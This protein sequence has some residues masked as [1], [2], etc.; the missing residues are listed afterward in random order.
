MRVYN[1]LLR[2]TYEGVCRAS[3]AQSQGNFFI[4]VKIMQNQEHLLGTPSDDAGCVFVMIDF[5]TM[6]VDYASK[7]SKCLLGIDARRIEE[8]LEV[9]DGMVIGNASP[10]LKERVAAL[11]PDGYC[12]TY[13]MRVHADTGERCWYQETLHRMKLGGANK[14]AYV[15]INRT[16]DRLNIQRLH[17]AIELAQQSNKAKS[18]F[19]AKMSH[20]IRT[21]INTIMGMA[22]IANDHAGDLEKM[23]ECLESIRV[24]SDHL[25]ALIN[26]VL[27]MSKIESES[28]DLQESSCSLDDVLAE[29]E[30]LIR[31]TAEAK[32]Q[33]FTIE[34][35]CVQHRT[36]AAD[37]L[38]LRQILLNL[39]TNA[40]KYT[41][42]QGA[43]SLVVS[44]LDSPN[45]RAVRLRFAVRDNGM[46]IAPEFID[47]LFSPFARAGDAVREGMQ[48]TGLGMTITKALVD[49]MNGV[50]GV[51]SATGEG[52]LFTVVLDFRAEDENLAEGRVEDAAAAMTSAAGAFAAGVS[53]GASA[54]AE[55][56]PASAG[57]PSS[58]PAPAGA[59]AASAPSSASV[60]A[61]EILRGKRFL[62]VE[63]NN[64]NRAILVELLSER[65][66]FVEEAENGKV[67]VALFASNAP[68]YF[69]A[70]LMDAMMPV[71]D[72][73]EATRRIRALACDRSDAACVPII[74]LTANAYA[75]DVK[76][77][78][79]AGMNAHVG[80][81]FNVDDLAR[82]L[83]Q[84]MP[85]GR[86]QVSASETQ[87]ARR[88]LSCQ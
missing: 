76:A 1:E 17:Q 25:L 7:N 36:F 55:G 42:E 88:E 79:E 72:G 11:L 66:A 67:A 9:L 22:Q 16:R 77:S 59:F 40:V 44:E 49:A 74:A 48:G 86:E 81:P 37:G 5:D 43:V 20:D 85:A 82:V 68:G 52:T 58:V 50:I 8:N 53:A 62:A 12:E 31:P 29:I 34:S 71:M 60:N 35:S 87:T 38:R 10:C 80:K 47:N 61:R 14:V 73:Y 46:G 78:L 21:P 39:L 45:A 27:D 28:V 30:V 63:D 4:G 32:H 19:L 75:D 57:A 54:P 15:L 13:Q 64:L 70:I 26:D 24:S 56:A 2:N 41:Q 23:S 3:I 69:D 83:A 18:S 84:T 6:S 51:E 33:S 65:G